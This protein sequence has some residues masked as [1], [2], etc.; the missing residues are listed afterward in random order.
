MGPIANLSLSGALR[1]NADVVMYCKIPEVNNSTRYS[2]IALPL[3]YDVMGGSG[4]GDEDN[5][6]R[7]WDEETE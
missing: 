5:E 1:L 7:V 2:L 6:G 4:L 3:R